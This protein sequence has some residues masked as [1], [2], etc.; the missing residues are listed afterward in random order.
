MQQQGDFKNSRGCEAFTSH[1]H[2]SPLGCRKVGLYAIQALYQELATYPK[3]GLVSPVDSGSHRD[4]NASLFFRSLFSLRRYFQDIALAGEGN[5]AFEVLKQIAIKA[6]Q[7]MMKATHGINTHRGA[8]FN[9]GLL[10]AGAGYSQKKR[11]PLQGEALGAIVRSK[12]GEA[13]KQHGE[14]LPKVSHGSLVASRYGAG[15]ALEEAFSGFPHVFNLGLPALQESLSK[16][17]DTKE[18]SVQS[19][20]NLI[21]I[22]PDT[23]LLYRGGMQG[24]QFAQDSARSFID[25][26][27]VHRPDWRKHAVAIHQEFIR[28]NLSP[29]GS[30]DLLA[31]TLF[32]NR[33]QSQW[34]A[35]KLT[36][37]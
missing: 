4:M 21:S 6:E 13:I 23:N 8:I 18:A 36:G 14:R 35:G 7:R 10:A 31:A 25:Q 1:F 20:F 37:R 29:G 5:P 11:L 26:G 34:L 27:G 32:V 2:A 30:A 33:L 12:W 22:L 16:G 19:L 24:L 3:P 28:R 15:G 9:L 17:V